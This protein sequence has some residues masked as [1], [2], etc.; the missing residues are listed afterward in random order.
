VNYEAHKFSLG[1]QTKGGFASAVEPSIQCQRQEGLNNTD[2]GLIAGV[3]VLGVLVLAILIVGY[4]LW[5]RWIRP[6]ET[7]EAAV[8]SPSVGSSIVPPN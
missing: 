7:P 1:L 5:R 2:K 4:L 3:V 8:E 6:T